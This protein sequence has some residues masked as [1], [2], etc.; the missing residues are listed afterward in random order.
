MGEQSFLDE[1]GE[2]ARHMQAKLLRMLQEREYRP[3]SAETRPM[4][5]SISA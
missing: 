4:L 3:A 5:R 1:I 2:L